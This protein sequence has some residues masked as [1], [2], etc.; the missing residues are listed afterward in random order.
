M[1]SSKAIVK[2]VFLLAVGAAVAD[3]NTVGEADAL[4]LKPFGLK[5]PLNALKKAGQV[6]GSVDVR[7]VPGALGAGA[8]RVAGFMNGD[9]Q[10]QAEKRRQDQIER[11]RELENR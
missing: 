3:V 9:A 2:G 1:P 11:D 6:V 4:M 8:G 10:R 7:R 5:N